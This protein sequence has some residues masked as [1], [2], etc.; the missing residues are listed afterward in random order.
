MSVLC[1]FCVKGASRGLI[2]QHCTQT[3][4]KTS[5]PTNLVAKEEFYKTNQTRLSCILNIIC[6]EQFM[7]DMYA[8]WTLCG[9]IEGFK[10]ERV[11]IERLVTKTE[12][13][14]TSLLYSI[15]CFSSKIEVHLNA[16]C[17][18]VMKHLI[19][20]QYLFY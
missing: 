12:L 4:K 19:P 6:T 7:Y 15:I 18:H 5:V 16:I 10:I 17:F 11:K 3:L 14:W 2:N 20:L 13:G 8:Q 9:V 1:N